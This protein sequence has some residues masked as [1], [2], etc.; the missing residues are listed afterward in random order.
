MLCTV[1]GGASRKRDG[2]L[3]TDLRMIA[4]VDGSVERRSRVWSYV[5]LGHRMGRER[6]DVLPCGVAVEIHVSL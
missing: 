4:S 5:V 3:V 6:R 1:V 2:G